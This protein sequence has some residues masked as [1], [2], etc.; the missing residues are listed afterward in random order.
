MSLDVKIYLTGSNGLETDLNIL[1][2]DSGNQLGG[3]KRN[4][5]DL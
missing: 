4:Q 2:Q 3:I 1:H 5:S